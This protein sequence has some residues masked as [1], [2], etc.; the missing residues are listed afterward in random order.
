VPLFVA[1]R[2]GS[3]LGL[4]RPEDPAATR[5]PAWADRFLVALSRLDRRLLRRTDLPFGS[6][7]FLVARVPDEPAGPTHGPS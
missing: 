3:R 2:L 7:V 4:R 1:D 6:S 5:L